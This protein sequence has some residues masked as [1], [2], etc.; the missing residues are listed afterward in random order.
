MILIL[1]SL[2]DIPGDYEPLSNR[3][4]LGQLSI[5][6]TFYIHFITWDF[7]T[8]H[9]PDVLKVLLM[10]LLACTWAIGLRIIQ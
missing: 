1:P 3:D 8:H 6:L 7:L 9:L 10:A 5:T 4:T 2:R